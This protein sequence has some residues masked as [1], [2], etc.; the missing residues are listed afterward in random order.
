LKEFPFDPQRKKNSVLIKDGSKN[1]LIVRGAPEEILKAC[2]IDK[3]EKEKILQLEADYGIEG[4]RSI[5][6]AIREIKKDYYNKEDENSKLK[7]ISIT[8]FEDPIKES[9]IPAIKK[10]KEKGITIKII[11][12]DGAEVAGAVGKKIGIIKDAGNVIT[13]AIIDSIE[14]EIELELICKNN[15]VFARC[16]PLHKYK[17]IKALEKNNRVAFLGEGIND[18]PALKAAHVGI[19]VKDASDIARDA[20]DIILLNKSLSVI[21]DGVDQGRAIIINISKYIKAT[22][23]SN[24]GNFY[25]I[26]FSTFFIKFL[27]MLPIQILLLNLLS[28]FPMMSIAT[29]SVDKEETKYPSRFNMKE[30]AVS[31]TILG[32]VSTAFDLVFF[33]TFLPHGEK[34]LQTAWFIGSVLTELSLIYSI[35][36]NKAFFKAKA[37]SKMIIIFTILAAATTIILPLCGIEKLGFIKLNIYLYILIISIALTYFACTEIAKIIYNKILNKNKAGL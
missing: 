11:T 7:F 12:G 29:D 36:T 10:A 14:N 27:P 34:T 3:K 37:P 21:I 20:A 28:D 22:L 31:A 6:I 33:F 9:T 15:N 23:T 19:V 1:I 2:V 25:A 24:F 26:V 17:I 16:T 8:G 13:G 32:L 5:A 30:F 35:R 18:A 4:K